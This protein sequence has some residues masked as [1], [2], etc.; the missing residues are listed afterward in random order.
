MFRLL[1][2]FSLALFPLLG[3]AFDWPLARLF[4]MSFKLLFL[5][6]ED[7]R[8]GM[9]LKPAP[10]ILDSGI[11]S[12][13]VTM[14]CGFRPLR[15]GKKKT[16]LDT[17][18]MT[19]KKLFLPL[20]GAL[21][22]GVFFGDTLGLLGAGDFVLGNSGDS[23]RDGLGPPVEIVPVDAPDALATEISPGETVPTGTSGFGDSE[24][25]R[26]GPPVEIVP[27]DAPDALATEILPGETVL[28]GTSGF[29][30]LRLPP[31]LT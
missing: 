3:A 27:L 19:T 30:G 11:S 25:D 24:E 5:D 21:G 18:N 4:A 8:A 26:L 23:E 6:A 29:G 2:L 1:G 16:V 14:R 22:P 17:E 13:T 12:V 20:L 10:A 9:A 7:P 15:P 31:N 28:T